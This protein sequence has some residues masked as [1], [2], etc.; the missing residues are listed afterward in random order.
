MLIKFNSLQEC[1][2][3]KSSVAYKQILLLNAISFLIMHKYRIF[4][5]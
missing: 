1:K 5:F 3:K 4:F 2:I